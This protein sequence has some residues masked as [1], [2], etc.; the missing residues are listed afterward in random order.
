MSCREQRGGASGRLR[1]LVVASLLVGLLVGIGCPSEATAQER[2]KGDGSIFS[3]AFEGQFA[4]S[5]ADEIMFALGLDLGF[6]VFRQFNV[7]LAFRVGGADVATGSRTA[8]DFV[9]RA[10]AYWFFMD[11][12]QPYLRGGVAL[13][14]RFGADLDSSFGAALEGGGGVR[15]WFG[16]CG[17][18]YS[19]FDQAYDWSFGICGFVGFE[20]RL[21]V[22]LTEGFL[23][24]P[25]IFPGGTWI[26]S[27]GFNVGMAL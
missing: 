23:Y 7:G 11:W 1:S 12:L 9:P 25:R 17:K 19:E 15:G 26:W 21:Q 2:N 18:T 20:S 10:E 8:L 5:P 14:P 27:S 16:D 6:F 22:V 4:L 24:S 3:L 13:Q